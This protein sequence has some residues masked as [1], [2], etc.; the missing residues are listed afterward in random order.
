MLISVSA[1]ITCSRGHYNEIL[2]VFGV[3]S[4]TE[5]KEILAKFASCLPDTGIERPSKKVFSAVNVDLYGYDPSQ[6]VAVVQARE[7]WRHERKGWTRMKKSYFLC[8]F[9]ESGT[10]FRHPVSSGAVRAA[11]KSADPVAVVRA[12][13]RWMWGV[14][15]RQ[16]ANGVRQGDVLMVR[17]RGEP[18]GQ[19]MGKVATLADSHRVEAARIVRTASGRIMALNP[20]M[21][22]TKNQHDPVVADVEGWHSIRVADEAPAWDFAVRMGD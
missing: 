13:Q 18:V 21:Y 9:N 11:A 22:H 17:E 10:P 19:D 2:S 15:P 7:F 20:W 5:A 12:A 14:T 3:E 8:G 1:E 6:N 4:R 16:L